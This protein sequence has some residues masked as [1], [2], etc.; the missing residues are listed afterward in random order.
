MTAHL[1]AREAIALV[2]T[3]RHA[4]LGIAGSPGAGKSTLVE[5]LLPRI[6]RL[7]ATTGSRTFP[8]T[9]STSPTPSSTGSAHAAARARPTRSTRTA[10][11]TFS[12]GWRED[13]EP[14]LRAWLRQDAGATAGRGAR[15]AA[16]RP[17]WS[18]PRAT[19]CSST[20][21]S[22]SRA[23]TA[24]DAVWFVVSRRRTCASQRLVER[25][26]SSA[27]PPTEARAWVAGHRPAQLRL[28]CRR[29]RRQG[30]PRHL[31]DGDRRLPNAR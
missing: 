24:M 6:R 4:I 17:V 14:D 1:L 13:D 7:K 31:G 23:A 5:Q 16:R 9:A 19:I 21:R 11:P 15:R 2:E 27:R 3:I 29:R 22:G 25:H 30:R 28:W 10:T 18:S 26:V 8:W 20:T 12:N